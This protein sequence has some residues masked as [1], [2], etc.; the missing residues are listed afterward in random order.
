MRDLDKLDV[1]VDVKD[2]YKQEMEKCLD[3][4]GTR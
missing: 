3:A 4:N 1:P 2:L